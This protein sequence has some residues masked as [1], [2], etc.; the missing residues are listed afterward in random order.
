MWATKTVLL[1][2][3]KIGV[4]LSISIVSLILD[5]NPRTGSSVWANST[6]FSLAS[7][8]DGNYQFCSKPEPQDGR[9]GDGVCFIVAKLGDRLDGYYGYPHSEMYVC[10]R[11]RAEGNQVSGYGLVLFWSTITTSEFTWQLDPRL[12]LQNGSVIRSQIGYHEELYWV[13]YDDLKLNIDGFHQY[14]IAKMHASPKMCEWK[15]P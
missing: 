8:D 7:L 15:T 9:D 2:L 10:I 4:P 14:P 11:G 6:S 3:L 1:K 5:V 13:Q 12:M